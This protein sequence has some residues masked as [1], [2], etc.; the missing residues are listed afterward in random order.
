[1]NVLD[2]F[3]ASPVAAVIFIITLITSL[4]AFRDPQLMYKFILNPYDI[5]RD[6]EYYRMFTSGL[7]HGNTTHLAVN[8]ISYYF[9]AFALEQMLGHWQFAVLYVGS[10]FLSDITTLIKHKDNPAYNALGASGAV[11][12]V[13]LSVVMCMPDLTLLLFFVIPMPG[14]FFAIAYI[15]YSYWAS[16]NSNDNIG[17][18]AHLWGAISGIVLTLILKP[19]VV[20]ILQEWILGIVYG[21]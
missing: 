17:H 9:F 4:Q 13:L 6:K 11:S 7:I 2:Q 1:M 5:V 8:M 21:R 19:D 16:K 10:L 18:E 3:L 20:F 14:W 12:A 15:G